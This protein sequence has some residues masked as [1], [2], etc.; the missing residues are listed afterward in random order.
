[1]FESNS[2]ICQTKQQQKSNIMK[3][4]YSPTSMNNKY[5]VK[6]Y[7]EIKEAGKNFGG[8]NVVEYK[9][10]TYFNLE[11]HYWVNKKTLDLI[12]EKYNALQ[13]YM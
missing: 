11:F 7:T 3:T 6:S 5:E 4:F 10:S 9:G 8:N 13:T 12:I 1:M 2:Y